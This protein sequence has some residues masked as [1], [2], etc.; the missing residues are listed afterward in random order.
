MYDP[1]EMYEQERAAAS[2]ISRKKRKIVVVLA[3]FT[4]GFHRIYVGKIGT[5]ILWMLTGG[6]FFVGQILDL[7]KLYKGEFT[8]KNGAYVVE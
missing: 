3:L 7:Y 8:D 1:V 6:C 5:G 2:K 4:W